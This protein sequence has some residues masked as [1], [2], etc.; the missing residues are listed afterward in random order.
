M[1][2]SSAVLGVLAG[3][4]VR[5]AWPSRELSSSVRDRS[6]LRTDIRHHRALPSGGHQHQGKETSWEILISFLQPTWVSDY[7]QTNPLTVQHLYWDCPLSGFAHIFLSW[8]SL[9]TPWWLMNFQ[10]E[11]D[12][13][14]I[15]YVLCN[16]PCLLS[17]NEPNKDPCFPTF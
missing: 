14:I 2:L 12:I 3:R 11:F 9:S 4:P 1:L 6:S 7:Q 5:A 15:K 16:R 10:T 13:I 17:G 8:L